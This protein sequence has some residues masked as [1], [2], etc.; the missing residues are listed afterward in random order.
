MG[1]ILDGLEDGRLEREVA[2]PKLKRYV[3]WVKDAQNAEEP[4]LG[5]PLLG[6]PKY[7]MDGTVYQGDWMRYGSTQY[8]YLHVSICK[9]RITDAIACYLI[10]PKMTVQHFVQLAQ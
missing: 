3:E 5:Q 8:Q 7:N 1:V 6:E 2:L 9:D 4:H 10:G